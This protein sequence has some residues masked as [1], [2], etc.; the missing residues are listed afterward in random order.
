MLSGTGAV[1]SPNVVSGTQTLSLGTLALGS[2]TGQ[3]SNYLLTGG[4]GSVT[5]K[6]LTI[7]G[8]RQY[9]G[10]SDFSS[11][12]FGLSGTISTGIGSETLVMSGS[13]SVTSPNVL[14]GTQSLSLGTLALT[15]G[16]GLGSNYTLSGGTGTVTTKSLTLQSVSVSDK[17]YDGTRDAT[18]SGFS[19]GGLVGSEQLGVNSYTALFDTSGASPAAKTVTVSGMTFKDGSNGGLLS[20]YTINGSGGTTTAH[21]NAAALTITANNASKVF[22]GVAYSGG[23]GVTYSAFAN[24]E[25]SS[26]LSGTLAYGGNSQGANSVGQYVI[27]PQGLN[28]NNYA[29]TY[30]NGQ[31]TINSATASSPHEPQFQEPSSDGSSAGADSVVDNTSTS[32]VADNALV[33]E[34]T[35]VDDL[36]GNGLVANNMPIDDLLGKG[37]VVNSLPIDDVPGKVPVSENMPVDDVPGKGLVA[38]NV[39]VDDIPGNG[40]LIENMPVDD[41]PDKGSVADNAPVKDV[42]DKGSVVNN[43]PVDDVPNS[44]PIYNNGPVD[45]TPDNGPTVDNK[46]VDDVPE[47]GSMVNNGPV[48]DNLYKGA[49]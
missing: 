39:P 12:A 32:A 42:N 13:G 17:T 21:L 33:A 9:D 8:T 44:G 38:E 28:S 41:I 43:V 37:I 18:L 24:G 6:G 47:N 19:L 40:L 10:T 16:S 1:T 34:N 30:V 3:S 5:P 26:V 31:L 35:P 45:D 14:S 36:P 48:D 22:D 20:N 2:G 11:S 49:G 29:I 25:T 23:N 4:T 27:A 7:S 46:P 15:N